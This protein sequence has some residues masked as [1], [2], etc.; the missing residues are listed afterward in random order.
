MY[1]MLLQSS[2]P[3]GFEVSQAFLVVI[4]LLIPAIIF[5]VGM[6]RDESDLEGPLA[7]IVGNSA[8][9][10]GKSLGIQALVIALI[11]IAI[12]LYYVLFSVVFEGVVSLSLPIVATASGF[13]IFFILL[14]LTILVWS[15]SSSGT[16]NKSEVE[17]VQNEV[18]R[19]ILKQRNKELKDEL[20][21]RKQEM[22]NLVTNFKRLKLALEKQDL[23][24]EE[25][26]QAA[27]DLL[28]TQDSGLEELSTDP[29]PSE[30]N[31]ETE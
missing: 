21:E 18:D 20:D 9:S 15:L 31:L 24:S 22:A 7:H 12:N 19:T 8:S 13:G 27:E 10:F 25:V 28:K 17:E 4:S 16:S 3:S 1:S 14:I 30:K 26:N 6:Y 11:A 5:I 23:D 2:G 29:E